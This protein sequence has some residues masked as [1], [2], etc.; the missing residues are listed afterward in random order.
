MALC[1][2]SVVQFDIEKFYRHMFIENIEENTINSKNLVYRSG[3]GYEKYQQV[4]FTGKIN[5]SETG[6]LKNG[7]WNGRYISYY[8]N[9]KKNGKHQSFW[10]DGN[11]RHK[12]NY[13]NGKRTGI[14]IFYDTDGITEKNIKTY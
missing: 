12:G 1:V 9:G 4:P 6:Y 3:L 11:L 5:G 10:S 13:K 7:M 2:F 8:K 14:W